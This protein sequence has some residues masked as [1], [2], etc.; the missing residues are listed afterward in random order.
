MSFLLKAD[1]NRKFCTEGAFYYLKLNEVKHICRGLAKISRRGVESDTADALFVLVNPGSC[2]PEDETY[3]FPAF[4]ED[5][6]QV[7]FVQAQTD[8]TQYQIMRLMERMKWNMVYIINLSDLRA[9]NMDE[10]RKLSNYFESNSDNRHNIF[11]S[12]RK[13]ILTSLLSKKTKIIAG[14]GKNTIIKER[15]KIALDVL[16]K[17]SEV[18]GIPYEKRPYYKHPFPMLQQKCIKWLDDIQQTLE[19]LKEIKYPEN[20]ALEKVEV[21][22]S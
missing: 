20:R 7:P 2:K 17:L 4:N 15:A 8:P 16:E 10:F 6:K 11:S 14:W 12:N 18:H 3:E 1:L 19:E 5:L 13:G 9:G 21:G 22:D